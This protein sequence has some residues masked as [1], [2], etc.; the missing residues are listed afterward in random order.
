MAIY[1][2]EYI[3]TC[4]SASTRAMHEIRAMLASAT[5]T[6]GM[7]LRRSGSCDRAASSPSK[8]LPVTSVNPTP[9]LWEYLIYSIFPSATIPWHQKARYEI[10]F[11]A[12]NVRLYHDG[13][14][15]EASFMS[16]EPREDDDIA[17]DDVPCHRR[18]HGRP[19][20]RGAGLG[21]AASAQV[22]TIQKC[23][24]SDGT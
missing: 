20:L 2:Y 4:A 17:G 15:G 16:W 8:S 3:Y 9:R 10:S 12:L 19:H 23:N 18:W 14:A 13:E 7:A 24:A 11:K 5:S 6:I 21:P 22:F 1:T